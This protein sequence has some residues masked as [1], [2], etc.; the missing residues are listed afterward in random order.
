MTPQEQE[1]LFARVKERFCNRPYTW[2]SGYVHGVVDGLERSEPRLEYLQDYKTRP[3]AGG[4]MY[5]FID[6]FGSDIDK[7]YENL[8]LDP[9]P[10]DY[11]W[12][13]K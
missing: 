7:W 2:A 13:E 6:A 10:A 12:W 4:Y 11:R 1:A 8:D 3:Y 9:N 5:G